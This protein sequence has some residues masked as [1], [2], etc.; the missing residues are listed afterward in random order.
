MRQKYLQKYL[1]VLFAVSVLLGLDAAFLPAEKPVEAR[2]VTPRD[3]VAEMAGR[4]KIPVVIAFS[5][6]EVE[7]GWNP[8]AVGLNGGGMDTADHG[9]MQVNARTARRAGVAEWI[10]L[11]DVQTNVELGMRHLAADRDWAA[12][13]E[14][15]KWA[16]WRKAL[17]AYNAGQANW[18]RGL[19]HADKV[20]ALVREELGELNL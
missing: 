8:N 18:R 10:R 15:S 19:G 4:L 2:P 14:K 7:S 11:H 9:L 5:A 6:V 20:L 3:I 13:T 1:V 16:I 12:K 17:A